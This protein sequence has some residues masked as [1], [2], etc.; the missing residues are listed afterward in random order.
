MGVTPKAQGRKPNIDMWN[1]STL[2]KLLHDQ[3]N[4][5]GTINRMNRQTTAEEKII[6]NHVS[7]KGLLCKIYKELVQLH[8]NKYREYD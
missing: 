7:D 3:Q 2:E 1:Y 6:G 8:D 5:K 4:A